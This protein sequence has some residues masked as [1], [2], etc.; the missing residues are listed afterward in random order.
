MAYNANITWIFLIRSKH[1]KKILLGEKHYSN[2][3]RCCEMKTFLWYSGRKV[4]KFSKLT[5]YGARSL[6]SCSLFKICHHYWIYAINV[7][8]LPRHLL[9]LFGFSH[10]MSSFYTVWGATFKTLHV[11][12]SIFFVD[13]VWMKYMFLWPSTEVKHSWQ[14]ALPF[15]LQAELRL[16]NHSSQLTFEGYTRNRFFLLW[17]RGSKCFPFHGGPS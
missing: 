12:L 8:Y 4:W 2:Y 11:L 7:L 6:K 13:R 3:L 5:G 10:R 9:Y 16:P 1:S 15:Q 17:L 14:P